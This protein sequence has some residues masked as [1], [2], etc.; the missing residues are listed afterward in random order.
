[1]TKR[2][3]PAKPSGSKS[4]QIEVSDNGPYLVTGN[5][6]LEVK[7]AKSDREG[8]AIAW[9]NGEKVETQGCYA[10]CR[11]GQSE[12]KP[13]C[14]GSHVV[15][16][17]DGEETAGDEEYLD[18]PSVTEGPALAMT[19]VEQLCSGARFCDAGEGT[20][21]LV[22]Q[23]DNPEAA[24]L[25]KEQACNCPSGRLTVFDKNGDA[26][27][28]KLKPVIGIVEDE[29]TG[30]SGPL[31]VQGGIPVKSADG[32]TY[33]VRNRVALCRCGRSGNKPFCDARHNDG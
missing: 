8:N 29:G 14:D 20:W 17:F 18:Q 4:M 1:M 33:R 9:Q 2:R 12:N 31:Y 7:I 19:D 24:K 32:K 21:S 11:C 26:I 6:P 27:E 16:G 3:T 25:A 10:L 30:I 5:V 15:T 22:E 23:S 28:P 13:F